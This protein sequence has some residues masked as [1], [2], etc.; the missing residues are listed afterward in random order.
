MVTRLGGCVQFWQ[1]YVKTTWVRCY[2]CVDDWLI[3]VCR[4]GYG[5]QASCSRLKYSD[6]ESW[7]YSSQQVPKATC[8]TASC[9]LFFLLLFIISAMIQMHRSSTVGGALFGK[10]GL[11]VWSSMFRYLFR[12]SHFCALKVNKL[13]Y[14]HAVLYYSGLKSLPLN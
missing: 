1:L 2:V 8:Q 11:L 10:A 7:C 13:N 3:F 6:H 9:K 12:I 5:C 14:Y 4:P